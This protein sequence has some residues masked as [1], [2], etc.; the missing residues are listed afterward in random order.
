MKTT[1]SLFFAFVVGTTL[2]QYP[3]NPDVDG[4]NFIGLVDFMS[5]LPLYDSPFE[6][7]DTLLT[8]V[9]PDLE[10]QTDGMTAYNLSNAYY[11]SLPDSVDVLV[12]PLEIVSNGIGFA[13]IIFSDTRTK[14]LLIYGAEDIT[15]HIEEGFFSVTF[16]S[17]WQDPF[18]Y[19]NPGGIPAYGILNDGEIGSTYP[20]SAHVLFKKFDRWYIK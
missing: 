9:F 7:E 1:F 16:R 8:V 4:D 18:L 6:V 3:F 11:Y 5:V 14:P 2:G 15:H 10:V 13:P 19:P 17:E 20:I 12:Q